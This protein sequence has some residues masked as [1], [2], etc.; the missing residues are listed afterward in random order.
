MPGYEGIMLSFF[1]KKQLKINL[2]I[3]NGG[4]GSDRENSER[5]NCDVPR[6]PG[7]RF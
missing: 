6:H 7:S 2:L 1:Y 3:L 4:V 5:A